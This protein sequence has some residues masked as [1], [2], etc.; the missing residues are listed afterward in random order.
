M[1]ITTFLTALLI[2]PLCA[3]PKLIPRGANWQYLDNGSAATNWTQLSFNDSSW[4]SGPAPLGYGD[5]DTLKTI[6]S[7]GTNPKAKPITTWFRHRFQL[8]DPSTVPG[9]QLELRRDD[10][11]VVYLNGKEIVRSAM[12][13][14]KLSAITTSKGT[15]SGAEETR[16]FPFSISPKHLV[17]GENL[18]AVEL[19]Q[20][21]TR[22]SDIAF[23]LS[24]TLDPGKVIRGPYLQQ[25]SDTALTVR[26]RTSIPMIGVLRYG[27]SPDQLSHSLSEQK[28]TTEHS[29]AVKGLPA[30]STSFYSIGTE[31]STLAGGDP[32]YSFTTS[33]APGTAANTRIWILGDCGT[34]NRN[35]KAVRDVFHNF[36]AKRPADLMLLLGD[37]AYGSGTDSE[38]QAA[39]FNI[40]P[41]SLRRIPVW[42]TLGNHDTAQQ[43]KFDGSYPYFDIFTL[44]CAGEA[45]GEPSGTEH[46]YSFDR[47]NVHLICLDSM[48]ADR[49]PKGAMATWLKADLNSTTATW[50]IAF[51][52]HPPYTK[53]S[54]NS[55]TEKQL[56]E[57]R[58]NI[59]PILEAGGIDLVFTGHSHSY[60]RT[61]LID[62]HYGNSK[63]FTDAMKKAPGSGNPA[64][65]GAYIKP[66]TGPRAHA[67]AIYTVA[68]SAGKTS[69]GSLDHPAMFFSISQLGSVV[70]DVNANQLTATFVSPTGKP[71]GKTH[72]TPDNFRIIKQGA[73]DRDGNGI[74]DEQEILK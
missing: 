67:G 56:V 21:S 61:F 22:S 53:G 71:L 51:W 64:N 69:G 70:L 8:D 43:T 31:S 33:P 57:M 48:T 37:N 50:I 68:G 11:A 15:T 14:G 34:A 38:Y 39:I 26:W 1:K 54:H 62:G 45:G 42:P 23:D 52:H 24:L 20:S 44:P 41:K 3:A 74:S 18:I 29:I 13:K 32:S 19:H 9:L 63:T 10:G 73:S 17:A 55:D 35:Q 4:K 2:A 58:E 5:K 72:S 40:Y 46:Y 28:P 16:Y 66:L 49:S 12:P 60:E 6:V 47:A 27:N 59:L 30:S 25:L 65:S 7:S 36:A